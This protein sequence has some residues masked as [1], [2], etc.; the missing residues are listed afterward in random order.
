MNVQDR[1]NLSN[2]QRPWFLTLLCYLTIFASSYMLVSSV[3]A[4][5]DLDQTTKLLSQSIEEASVMFESAF[6]ADPA[7]AEKV[8]EALGQIAAGN[9]RSNMRDHHVFNMINNLLTLLG[10]SLMLRLRK[11]G[12]HLYVLGNLIGIA[13]PLLVFGSG[14]FL[15]FA[16]SFSTAFFGGLF[17]LLYALKIK[18]MH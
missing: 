17:V 5:S 10:A 11:R 9:T 3:S 2:T 6:S 1:Q 8:G 15:G 16:F 18:Y 12:F 4:L 13:A 14:N 7:T